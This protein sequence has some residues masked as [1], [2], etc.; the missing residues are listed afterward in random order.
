MITVSDVALFTYVTIARHS[1]R[2][3]EVPLRRP[4]TESNN[5]PLHGY[6]STGKE[7]SVPSVSERGWV[8]RY[9]TPRCE[10][11]RADEGQW[12]ILKS[13]LIK[14]GFQI[15]EI[16]PDSIN[17]YSAGAPEMANETQ[18]SFVDVGWIKRY[19][20]V[21]TPTTL[22]FDGDG[23]MIWSHMGTMDKNDRK[24]AIKASLFDW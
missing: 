11:C 22:L 15:Y 17:S 24:S 19:R 3:L 21:G 16:P 13:L 4:S 6:S 9:T 5:V 1:N 20:F 18:I 7:V 8:V 23:K 2:I 12:S 10:Y 14:K